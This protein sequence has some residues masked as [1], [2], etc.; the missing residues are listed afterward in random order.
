MSDI[1]FEIFKDVIGIV[2]A[3]SFEHMCLFEERKDLNWIENGQGLSFSVGSIGK[4]PVCITVFVE[5][6]NDKRVVFWDA[7]SQVVDYTMIHKWF[8]RHL[9]I[10]A[11]K[12]A[13]DDIPRVN[14]VD[15][16]NFH[17]IFR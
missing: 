17:N 5:T 10:S 11:F 14:S 3:N 9:P 6:I 16:M 1:S 4:R 13:H 7:T 8:E 2:E 12:K 15:A